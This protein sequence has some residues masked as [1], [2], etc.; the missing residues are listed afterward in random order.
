MERFTVRTNAGKQ[1]ELRNHSEEQFELLFV[2]RW[3]KIAEVSLHRTEA[4]TKR[5][6]QCEWTKK[7]TTAPR[8]ARNTDKK[9]SAEALVKL[10]EIALWNS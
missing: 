4:K 1:T 6:R 5:N 7:A 2:A 3:N 10:I 9:A 8:T